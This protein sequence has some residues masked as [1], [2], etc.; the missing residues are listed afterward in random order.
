MVA[1]AKKRS[2]AERVTYPFRPTLPAVTCHDPFSVL[3]ER[4]GHSQRCDVVPLLIVVETVGGGRYLLR[5]GV[6][7][8]ELRAFFVA[9]SFVHLEEVLA[10][11]E[12]LVRL[13]D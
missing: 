11:P 5:L 13:L 1:K 3:R 9:V 7:P 6:L 10:T 4:V 12:V 8:E 2:L